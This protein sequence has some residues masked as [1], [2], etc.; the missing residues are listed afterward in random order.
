MRSDSQFVRL[1]CG[2]FSFFIVVATLGCGSNNSGSGTSTG[3][4]TGTTT[5]SSP[6]LVA[7][8]TTPTTVN[9]AIGAT[10]Q[11]TAMASYS[12]GSSSNV[13]STATW[14]SKTTSVATVSSGGMVTGVAAGSTTV[15]ATVNGISGSATVTVPAAAP[16]LS[17][18][19]VTPASP[20]V[21]V[22]GTQQFTATGTYSDGTTKPI[23]S[24]VTW[25]TASS[26]IATISSAGVATGVAAGTTTVTASQNGVNGT[27]SITVN[28]PVISTIAITPSTASLNVGNTQQFTATA[29][30]SNSPNG[31]VTSSVTWASSSTS[32]ATIS[33]SGLLTGVSA[34]STSITA[35]LNGV[36]SNTAKVTIT[37]ISSSGVDIPT[38]HVDNNRSG[39]NSSETSL[40]TSNVNASSF[41]KLFSL[42]VDGYVYGEPLIM[43]NLTIKGAQHNVIYVATEYDSVYAFDADNFN[44]GTPLWKTS[45]LNYGTNT[46]E[47]PLTS[48]AIKPYEG[49]TS[50]P[51]I[52][53]STNTL[54][55]VSAQQS[56]GNGSFRLSAL[57][58]TTGAIKNAVT[59]SASVPGTVD[60][61]SVDTL[62]T[63]CIQRAALLLA[64]NTIYIGVGDCPTGWLLAYD[65]SNLTQVNVWNASPNQA[66]EG[67]YASA[68]GVWMGSGGP[69]A[70]SSGNVYIS[71]GNGPWDGITAWSDSVLQFSPGLTQNKSNFFTPYDYQYMDCDDTDV[72]A[73]GV[74]IIPGTTQLIAGGKQ[75]KIFLLNTGSL[76]GEQA[77]NAGA[78]QQLW[79]DIGSAPYSSTCGGYTTDISSYE[80]FGTGAFYNGSVYVGVS[81]TGSG[82]P[83]GVGRFTYSSGSG[84]SLNSSSYTPNVQGLNTRGT[85]PFISSNGNS[86]GIVW[87]ISEGSPLQE[88]NTS[89]ATLYAF[90]AGNLQSEL[91]SSSTNAA[92]TPGYGIKFTSPVEANGKVYISTGHDLTTVSN[93]Q[94][95]ID[96]Y[97]LK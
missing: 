46:N 60:G 36:T 94:G 97:G 84:G 27:A 82:A 8:T 43:S 53:A 25:T 22:G 38:W 89:T 16:T 66:G 23:T 34:G 67:T 32:V 69:A 62:T 55:V 49:V 45:L 9:V 70:D 33:S 86:N 52:D 90:D 65:A 75:G 85:T 96:V 6:S 48:A 14:S 41:G 35:S 93:P 72:A 29:T 76:G 40:T 91:Y 61:G 59:I 30:Y 50:T 7:I 47:T 64:N 11:F 71:T 17:T 44:N 21:T 78:A 56:N 24:S 2:A 77:N 3:T 20:S 37:V 5:G 81:P 28:A 54:Y 26:S 95:E 18:I 74:M 39:L 58:I 83:G 73:G 1:F 63:G 42:P 10:Q 68:G 4:S 12:D 51:V 15:T 13:T 31:N 19:A 80:I 87:L 79:Y 92:D 88:S 57:D